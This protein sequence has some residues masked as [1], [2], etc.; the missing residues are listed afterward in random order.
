MHSRYYWRCVVVSIN[1]AQLLNCCD[2]KFRNTAEIM[3]SMYWTITMVIISMT[4]IA[5]SLNDL[6]HCYDGIII[7]LNAS[8]SMDFLDCY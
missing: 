7:T 3:D 5:N 8:I 4:M 2:S 1:L 6:V